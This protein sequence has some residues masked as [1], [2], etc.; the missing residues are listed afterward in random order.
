MELIKASQKGFIWGFFDHG[1]SQLYHVYLY[2][3][4]V[5][6]TCTLQYPPSLIFHMSTISDSFN[7]YMHQKIVDQKITVI[8]CAL[9]KASLW[10]TS[11]LVKNNW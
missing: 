1:I 10:R 8:N 11:T 7:V 6:N 9:D 4:I 2:D 3:I 5:I